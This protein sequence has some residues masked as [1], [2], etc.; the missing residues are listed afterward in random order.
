MQETRQHI[1]EILREA[2]QAT[3]DDIVNELCRRRGEIT[4]VT[5]RHHLTRLQQDNLITAP[6]LRHRST[7]GRP[8]HIYA[9][10]DKAREHFPNNYQHLAAGLLKQIAAHVPS[11]GVNVILEGVADSMAEEAQVNHR[12]APIDKRLDV[13]VSYLNDHGYNANWEKTPDGYVLNTHN[14]PYHHISEKTDMLCSMDMRLV[15]SLLGVVP[16]L[17]SRV[18]DG[19]T[20]C[21]YLIPESTV[22]PE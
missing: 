2:G 12:E 6:K 11:D 5:V 10:T 8:Q 7:P 21:A 14:C 9:L 16:R 22:E 19:D 4:A 20:S 13:V 3:V 15:S 17:L 18:S 1:L